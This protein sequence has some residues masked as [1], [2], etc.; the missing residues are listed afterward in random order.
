MKA[1]Y[2]A[3]P[4]PFFYCTRS[5]WGPLNL[6]VWPPFQRKKLYG[7]RSSLWRY[8]QTRENILSCNKSSTISKKS[9]VGFHMVRDH[10]RHSDFI[11]CERRDL[12]R[13]RRSRSAASRPKKARSARQEVDL[14][15]VYKSSCSKLY[16]VIANK[17]VCQSFGLCFI[18]VSLFE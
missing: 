12:S 10:M 8:Q 1:L 14:Y 15:Q 18:E 13:L 2:W 5:S 11:W 16:F 17:C 4:F 9:F 7:T 6:K 3:F